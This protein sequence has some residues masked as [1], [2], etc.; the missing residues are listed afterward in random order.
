MITSALYGASAMGCL[1]VAIVFLRH[2][3]RSLDRL[4]IAFAAAFGG[5]RFAHDLARIG[6]DAAFGGKGHVAGSAAESPRHL[7]PGREQSV[8]GEV[9]EK[10]RGTVALDI[11]GRGAQHAPAVGQP[12]GDQPAIQQVRDPNGDIEAGFEE[13]AIVVGQL[14]L[15]SDLRIGRQ[16]IGE[17]RG[18]IQA[19]E[20]CRRGYPKRSRRLTDTGKHARFGRANRGEDRHDVGMELR[21]RCGER[22]AP[23]R[24]TDQLA[25]EPCLQPRQAFRCHGLRQ[26]H[27]AGRR[28][29]AAFLHDMRE[30]LVIGVEHSFPQ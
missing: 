22:H 25:A 28:R 23:R 18:D 6:Q 12:F 19:S 2:W 1:A 9:G 11:S 4:F 14:E 26:A 20:R 30:Q 7:S 15:G 21:A 24:S 27:R 13:V 29:D 17:D 8:L 10:S 3:R 5:S 16:E